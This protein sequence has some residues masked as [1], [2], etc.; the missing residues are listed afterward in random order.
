MFKKKLITFCLYSILS[1]V[2]VSTCYGHT[3]VENKCPSKVIYTF[4]SENFVS[5]KIQKF[6]TKHHLLNV[7]H[8]ETPAYYPVHK[9]KIV[10]KNQPERMIIS[11]FEGVV[12]EVV[13]LELDQRGFGVEFLVTDKPSARGY[14]Y[15]LLP[16]SSL[17]TGRVSLEGE[18][19]EV[20]EKSIQRYWS[21]PES[22]Y[23]MFTD[24]NDDGECEI[25]NFNENFQQEFTYPRWYVNPEVYSFNAS[26]GRAK[27]N[28]KLTRNFVDTLWSDQKYKLSQI[29][30]RIKRSKNTLEFFNKMP[31]F[32]LGISA[33]LYLSTAKQVNKYDSA[34]NDLQL[35]MRE[36]QKLEVTDGFDTPP[37]YF[38]LVSRQK[39]S[40]YAKTSQRLSIFT[41][42]E[43]IDL[44]SL[45][46]L[47]RD[48]N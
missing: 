32:D 3:I 18:F 25:V 1:P 5:G 47:I 9:L 30:N 14:Q 11:K 44:K 12:F 8:F 43:L 38:G 36:F 6:E 21:L 23:P 2:L 20:S 28:T 4:D 33:T 22:Y 46:E 17:D 19:D 7:V 42:Q 35:L 13:E 24:I 15:S 45:Y 34:L 48:L 39:F 41:K 37:L 40:D 31:E 10:S 16:N 27:L 29:R 26:L